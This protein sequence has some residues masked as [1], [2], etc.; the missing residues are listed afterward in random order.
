M[1]TKQ[2]LLAGKGDYALY[3]APSYGP[4]FGNHEIHVFSGAD[5]TGRCVPNSCTYQRPPGGGNFTN[6]FTGSEH[7]KLAE[8]EVYKV[9]AE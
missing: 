4:T 3:D 2:V 8:V 5:R 1:P 6:L 9:T 7:F